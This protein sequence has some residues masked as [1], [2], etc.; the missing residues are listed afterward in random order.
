MGFF[1]DL[2]IGDLV[3]G[4]REMSS[5]ITSLKDDLIGSVTGPVD[6]LQNAVQDITSDITGVVPD[7]TDTT[8]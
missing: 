7:V 6:D 8:E 3:T 1:D 2:G 4:I 5:E